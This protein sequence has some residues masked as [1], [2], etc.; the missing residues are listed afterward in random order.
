[1]RFTGQE[2]LLSL[3]GLDETTKKGTGLSLTI[4][5]Y[6]SWVYTYQH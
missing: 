4:L 1:M 6:T 2:R 5:V 3:E